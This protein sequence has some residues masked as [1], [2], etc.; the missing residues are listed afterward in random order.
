MDVGPGSEG[1]EEEAAAASALA[2]AS[3][4]VGRPRLR[5]SGGWSVGEGSEKGGLTVDGFGR[6]SRPDVGPW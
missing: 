5:L 2:R 6:I 1:P 3:A 4:L